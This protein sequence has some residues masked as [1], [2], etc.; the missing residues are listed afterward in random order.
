MVQLGSLRRSFLQAPVSALGLWQRPSAVIA[1]QS[2]RRLMQQ[3]RDPRHIEWVDSTPSQSSTAAQQ[4]AAETSAIRP[5]RRFRDNPG[6][7]CARIIYC[8]LAGLPAAQTPPPTL[9]PDPP[10][11]P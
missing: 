6:R 9:L 4:A 11:H 7:A 3:R 5:S 1:L 10:P 2:S 8:H